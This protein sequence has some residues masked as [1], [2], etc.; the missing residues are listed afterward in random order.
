[1]AI[2]LNKETE[3]Q[4]LGS[5]QRFFSSELDQDIGQLKAKMMLDFCLQEIGPGIYNQA[6]SDA[7]TTMHDRVT[8]LD[9]TC[10]EQEYTYWK[11]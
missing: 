9:I 5:I 8:E 6:I 3:E 4:L 10:H 11:K 2:K 7:Q 1:M